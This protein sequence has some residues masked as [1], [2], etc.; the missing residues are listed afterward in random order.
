MITLK[1]CKKD[2]LVFTSHIDLLRLM[3]RT[4]RRADLPVA[5]SQGF[6]PHMLVNLGITLPLGVAS[7]CEYVTVD[8]DCTAQDFLD[9]YNAAAAK[10]MRGVAA[11]Q[12][13]KNPNL[14]GTV[15]AADYHFDVNPGDAAQQIKALATRGSYVIEYPTKKD[16]HA[17]KDVAPLLYAIDVTESGMDVQMAAGNTTVRPQ[18]LADAIARE[19]GVIFAT[20]GITRLRQYVPDKTGGR[21]E[22]DSLLDGLSGDKAYV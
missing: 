10:G 8:A 9:R 15:C 11:W 13:P 12:V 3:E 4:L 16:E 1:Y 20:G 14:A 6:N 5:Y 17:Q 7:V 2:A 18:T 21:I 22:V 19:F